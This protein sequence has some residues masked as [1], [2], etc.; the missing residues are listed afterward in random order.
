MNKPL[1]FVAT[2]TLILSGCSNEYTPTA[3]SSGEE[4]FKAACMECHTPVEGKNNIYY[5]LTADKK[6]LAYIEAKIS[7]GSLMMPRFPNLT[8]DSLKAVSQ[9]ALEHSIEKK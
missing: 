6:N 2:G 3:E 4:I 5:E 9:Y 1:L 7:E 8:G